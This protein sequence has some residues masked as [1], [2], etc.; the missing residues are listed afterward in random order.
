M[1]R[2]AQAVTRITRRPTTKQASE[3]ETAKP[4]TANVKAT[5]D[6]SSASVR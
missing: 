6:V 3:S 1:R 4:V 5:M 2:N